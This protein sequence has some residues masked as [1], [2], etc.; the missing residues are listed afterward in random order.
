MNSGAVTT[1]PISPA[2]SAIA[3]QKGTPSDSAHPVGTGEKKPAAPFWWRFILSVILAVVVLGIAFRI[4][5]FFASFKAD[6]PRDDPSVELIRVEAYQVERASLQR[7]VNSFGTARADRV[8]TVSAEVSGKVTGTNDLRVGRFLSGPPNSGNEKGESVDSPGELILQIDPKTYQNR[9]EQAQATVKQDEASLQLLEE[10]NETNENLLENLRQRIETVQRDLDRQ[11]EL[12]NKQA[13][14]QSA[15]DRAK[16]ELDQMNET[17]IRLKSENN[18]YDDRKKEMEARKRSHEIDVELALEDLQK[19]TV[20]AP[21]SGGIQ[22]VF[23][24][25]G[26]YVRPGDPLVEISDSER[27]EVPI[28]LSIGDAAKVQSLIEQQVF[29]IVQLARDQEGFRPNANGG[30]VWTGQISRLAPQAD[31]QTRTVKAYVEVLNREQDE[32]LKPGT[33][34]YARIRADQFSQDDGVLVPRDAIVD[35]EVFLAVPVDD[36]QAGV[37]RIA[38]RRPIEIAATIQTF[39]LVRS[40]VQPGDEVVM[41][42]LDILTDGAALNVR[43]YHGL[44]EELSRVRVPH[45]E[46]IPSND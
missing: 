40:G 42:N 6:P 8:V 32:P 31:E 10:E 37:T 27:I 28:P 3:E 43:D 17:N 9:W 20:Y 46:R 35:K 18:L 19:A 39:A 36:S 22:Q 12:L 26:Q 24:E 21:F 4:F 14:S 34:V 45:L 30:T 41:T 13:G 29:P 7:Y 5:G 2:S 25:L 38:R 23:V 1:Q 16:L 11:I 15:V 33:F 44:D